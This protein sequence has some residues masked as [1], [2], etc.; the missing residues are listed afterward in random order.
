MSEPHRDPEIERRAR[1]G[2]NVAL[3]L[4]LVLFVILI[5]VV[6]IVRLGANVLDRPI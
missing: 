6:T 5:F 2:R 4:G 1:R 3:A